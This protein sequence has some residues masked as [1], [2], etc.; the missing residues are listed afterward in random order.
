[1]LQS[2]YFFIYKPSLAP[3]SAKEESVILSRKV[4]RGQTTYKPL[5]NKYINL[6]ELSRC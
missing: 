6:S 5:P 2:F 4:Y 3:K 1:M